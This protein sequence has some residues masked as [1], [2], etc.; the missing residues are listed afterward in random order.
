MKGFNNLGNTCYLNSGL[1]MLIQ[2]QDLCNMIKAFRDKSQI[3]GKFSE[4]ID[5][6]YSKGQNS[7][8]PTL[9]K[10]IA[11]GRNSIF[12]G[13]QQQDSSEFIVFLLDFINNEVNKVCSAKNLI[14]KIFELEITTST[15]CKVLSCLTISNNIEKS[16]ML[17]LNVNSECSTLDDCFNLSKQRVKLEGDEKYYCEKCEK[18]RIASQRKEVTQWPKNLIVWLRRYE[19]RGQRLSKYSQ[20]IQVPV[21]WRNNYILKGVVFHSGS[22]YGGHYVYAGL[23]DGKWYLFNDSSVSELDHGSL[24][25]IVNNGYIYYYDKS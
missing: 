15:K 18:K 4:F 6:Y 12:M 8:S 17:M 23:N 11:S 7:L 20:Q 25:N 22:L 2:N 21:K 19:Q 5:E 1:Q 3:L 10:E 9:I 24:A 16:T 14:D 13:F